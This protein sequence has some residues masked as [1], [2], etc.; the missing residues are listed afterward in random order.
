M[1]KITAPLT[2]AIFMITMVSG[3]ITLLA[4]SGDTELAASPSVMQCMTN[5]IKHEGKTASAKTTCKL[6]CADVAMPRL[7]DGPRD[8]MAV[9]KKCN[10]T[11]PK[12][13]TSCRRACKAQLM[14]CK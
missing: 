3:S 5:C 8:C 14:Q 10:R 12:G 7:Q 9:Y 4:A 13:D 2:I 6:R 11:C 1:R